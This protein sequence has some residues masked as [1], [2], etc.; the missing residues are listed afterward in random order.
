MVTDSVGTHELPVVRMSASHLKWADLVKCM[1]REQ[2][3]KA[4]DIAAQVNLLIDT[5]VWNIPDELAFTDPALCT[6]AKRK[7][8]SFVERRNSVLLE[9]LP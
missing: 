1:K 8:T 2:A 3:I 5:E 4:K 6:I 9:K 7:L